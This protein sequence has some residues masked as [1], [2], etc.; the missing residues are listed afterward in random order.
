MK[1]RLVEYDSNIITQSMLD[2]YQLNVDEQISK[3]KSLIKRSQS[4]SNMKPIMILD[5]NHLVGSFCLHVNDGPLAYGGNFGTDILVRAFSIDS[6]YRRKDFALVALLQLPEFIYYHYKGIER[7]IIA[8]N[9]N[10]FPAQALYIKA[11]FVD[12]QRRAVGKLG[13]LFIYQ[14]DI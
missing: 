13:E 10:N 11:G 2:D 1:I 12:T 6:R 9:H 14:K 7:I 4:N 3:P 8:V 5:D